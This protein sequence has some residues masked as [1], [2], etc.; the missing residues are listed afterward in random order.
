MRPR[1]SHLFSP[2]YYPLRN[3][4]MILECLPAEKSRD[5]VTI[6]EKELLSV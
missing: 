6:T 2:L 5:T 3:V 4:T 1:K